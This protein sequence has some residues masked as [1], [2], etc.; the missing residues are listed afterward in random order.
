MENGKALHTLGLAASDRLL[1]P[2]LRL[3]GKPT[4]R[5]AVPERVTGAA[6]IKPRASSPANGR[7][8]LSRP[9]ARGLRAQRLASAANIG[10]ASASSTHGVTVSSSRS[11]H[12]ANH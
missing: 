4:Q 7:F 10:P 11:A 12:S 9:F 3:P 2:S 8:L 5:L 1:P 6:L